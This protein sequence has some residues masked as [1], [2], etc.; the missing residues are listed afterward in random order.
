LK[1]KPGENKNSRNSKYENNKYLFPKTILIYIN[2]TMRKTTE[3][4]FDLKCTVT[5]RENLPILA[6][7]MVIFVGLFV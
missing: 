3:T 6:V 1:Q 2:E 5:P 4:R 7:C